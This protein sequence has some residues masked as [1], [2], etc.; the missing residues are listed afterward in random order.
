[1]AHL[2]PQSSTTPIGRQRS[3][4]AIMALVSWYWRRQ[5]PLFLLINLGMI[6]IVFLICLVPALAELAP[7]TELHLRLTIAYLPLMSIAL[8]GVA[9]LAF[10]LHLMAKILVERQS[11]TLAVLHNQG[12]SMRQILGS[13]L[14]QSVGMAL[15]ACIV[16]PVL[17]YGV[18]TSLLP[19]RY[20][21]R[22]FWH[23]LLPHFSYIGMYDGGAVLLALSIIIATFYYTMR[24][25]MPHLDQETRKES[26]RLPAALEVLGALI[27]LALYV[28]LLALFRPTDNTVPPRFPLLTPLAPTLLFVGLLPLCLRGTTL[29]AKVGIL[30]MQPG[31]TPLPMFSAL[32][33]IRPLRTLTRMTI[34]IALATAFTLFTL[35]FAT[36]QDRRINDIAA[37]SIG[38]DFSGTLDESAPPSYMTA[39]AA[40]YRSIRGAISVT[41]GAIDTVT[42]EKSGTTIQIQAVDATTFA[43]TAIWPQQD[44]GPTLPQMMQLLLDQRPMASQYHIVPAIVD[45]ITAQTLSLRPGMAFTLHDPNGPN[46]A[47]H[48]L[49]LA[50]IPHIPGTN[51]GILVDYQSLA[52][53]QAKNG[54]AVLPVNHVWLRTSSDETS[55]K[56]VRKVITTS[57]RLDDLLDRHF[58]L[59]ALQS[60]PLVQVVQSILIISTAIALV[61]A[62]LG[63]VLAFRISNTHRKVNRALLHAL[64]TEPGHVASLLI[65]EQAGAYLMALLAGLLTGLLLALTL[66]PILLNH[67]PLRS[68]ASPSTTWY[69]SQQ[70]LSA[71]VVIPAPLGIA[72]G[73][74]LLLV[75]LMLILLVRMLS[76]PALYH[77][78]QMTDNYQA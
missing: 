2:T 68:A 18:A 11:H 9:L 51:N 59:T 27:A 24:K 76:R 44:A 4:P 77:I 66:V 10:F 69:T 32:H 53:Y 17:A 13:L 29:L 34:L 56:N 58:L 12:A 20:G 22:S 21:F 5:W 54:L 48:Y 28:L 70:L 31:Y 75:P 65:W 47:A 78:L 30:M 25:R 6:G 1:M 62:L 38:T 67:I 33:R 52:D 16:G 3:L 57:L 37:S 41:I 63:N 72:L 36:S 74:V 15:T 14:P 45:D 23:D 64:E 40:Q 8:Q 39:I 60:D 46:R 71:P 43:Q 55:L 26:V 7:T 61:L 49:V 42:D 35:I 50:S 73:L 19:V